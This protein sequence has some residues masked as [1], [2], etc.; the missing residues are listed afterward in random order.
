[1]QGVDV[2]L[3]YGVAYIAQ[4]LTDDGK[5][6]V[7]RAWWGTRQQNLIFYKDLTKE[8]SKNGG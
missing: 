7:I 5:Y 6:L 4:G 3:N 2:I 1:M 8:G